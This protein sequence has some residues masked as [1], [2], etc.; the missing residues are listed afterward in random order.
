MDP[1]GVPEDHPGLQ[2]D[3]G[4][5]PGIRPVIDMGTQCPDWR[6]FLQARGYTLPDIHGATYSV[7]GPANA[8]EPGPELVIFDKTHTDTYFL[9]DALMNFI[10]QHEGPGW[11]TH[12]SLRAPHP[13]WVAAAPYNHRYPLDNLPTPQRQADIEAEQATHP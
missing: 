13:P 7:R 4:I 9:T 6:H 3:E 8:S 1:R 2:N 10:D 5:L 12:L 11:C